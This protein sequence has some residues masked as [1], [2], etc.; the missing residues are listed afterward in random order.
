M[1]LKRSTLWTIYIAARPFG[2]APFKLIV[3]TDGGQPYARPSRSARLYSSLTT[4]STS[5]ILLYLHT[6]NLLHFLHRV[7][8]GK[9]VV[10]ISS[11]EMIFS[12]FRT[13]FIGAIQQKNH[14]TFCTII[15][16]GF[17][18]H[19]HLQQL[20]ARICPAERRQ[21]FDKK[22]KRLIVVK[23]CSVTYDFVYLSSCIYFYP[24][25]WTESDLTNLPFAMLATLFSDLIVILMSN[26]YFC[27]M[28][29]ALQFY[30][31][32]N[33]M[34]TVV[35]RDIQ[36]VTADDDDG[37]RHQIKQKFYR[38]ADERLTCIA[39]LYGSITNYTNSFVKL[40]SVFI[41]LTILNASLLILCGVW[42]KS[43]SF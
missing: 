32:L 25:F 36:N 34:L 17:R 31:R 40:L 2:L 10:L 39:A 26:V 21:F 28:L 11:F 3:P 14:R 24:L 23:I 5:L 37:E 19:A 29:I 33:Y 38:D 27:G 18:V 7:S 1:S 4:I 20:F 6:I 15:N 42:L 8:G 9:T 41:L 12:C 16:D 13:I 30:R 22:C 43:L 35:M